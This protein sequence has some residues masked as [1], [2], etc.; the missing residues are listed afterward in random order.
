MANS[1]W[2][3]HLFAAPAVWVAWLRG[4]PAV[5]NYRG[6]DADAFFSRQ[7]GWIR[8]TLRRA[9]E[10]IVPS[11]FLRAVFERHGETATVVSNVVDL[12]AF[13][14]ADVLPRAPHL[15]VTR[16]L[17]AIYDVAT[18][19]RA[20][21]EVVRFH[22]GARLTIAGS[23]PERA[24]LERVAADLGLG[25]RVRFT[26]R[27]DNAKLPQLYRSATLMLN[28]ARID[29]M[30]NSLL[31]AMASGV[32]IVSTSV[33]G[34]PW[35]VEDGVSALLV[36]PGD[37]SAMAQAALRILD[38]PALQGR[39]AAAGI[40]AVQRH[41]WARVRADLLAAYARAVGKR[42]PGIARA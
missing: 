10:A 3:W 39:L 13:R 4:V 19:I 23:G 34:I 12:E 28:P 16:N 2:A 14:P 27:L 11:G 26:G 9:A 20:F 7:I 31:E 38:D 30:P 18:A 40:G 1:G 41:S 36:G 42:A 25:D 17:E 32:P 15:V 22:P 35:M 6:G 8:P 29:N 21:A 5:V 24:A 33:G 37:A